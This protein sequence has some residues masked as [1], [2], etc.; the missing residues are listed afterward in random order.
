[1]SG[2]CRRCVFV[3]GIGGDLFFERGDDGF[4]LRLGDGGLFDDG[5]GAEA[6]VVLHRATTVDDVGAVKGEPWIACLCHALDNS[7]EIVPGGEAIADEEDVQ[8]LLRFFSSRSEGGDKKEGDD[9]TGDA[10]EE[11]HA[12]GNDG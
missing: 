8:R 4:F 11:S 9:W 3:L 5:L 6:P 1:M 2:K 10:I 12:V 7:G